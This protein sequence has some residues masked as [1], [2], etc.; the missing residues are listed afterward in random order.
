MPFL[1]VIGRVYHLWFVGRTGVNY[2]VVMRSL[3]GL[4]GLLCISQFCLSLSL[5]FDNHHHHHHWGLAVPPHTS[6]TLES[7]QVSL[8]PVEIMPDPDPAV[9]GNANNWL[10]YYLLNTHHNTPHSITL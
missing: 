2:P 1:Y 3:A 9:N 6:H 8:A 10:D 7:H 5:T 4:A